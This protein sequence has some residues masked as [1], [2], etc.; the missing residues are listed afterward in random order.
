MI[1]GAPQLPPGYAIFYSASSAGFDFYGTTW[2]VFTTTGNDQMEWDH[3]DD[4]NGQNA[5][6]A[7]AVRQFRRLKSPALYSFC[8][9]DLCA[10]GIT[11]YAGLL[12]ATD[13]DLYGTTQG[14]GANRAGTVFKIG[15]TGAL[16]TLYSFCAVGGAECKDGAAPSATL[17]Q[18]SDGSFYGTTPLG[19]RNGHGTVFKIS[20][21]G[22][23]S[24]LYS[25]CS[26]G[27]GECTDGAAPSAGLTQG[28]DG[29][30]YGVTES[31]GAYA[32]GGTAFRIAPTGALTTLY[33]FCVIA[34]VDNCQEGTGIAHGVGLLQG[35]DGNLYGTT[36]QDGTVFR[37]TTD[38]AL[39]TLYTFCS[40]AKCADGFLPNA[41]LIEGIDGNFYGTTAG[42]GAHRWGT[43]FRLTPGGRLTTLYNFCSSAHCADGR[44]PVGSLTQGNHGDLYGVTQA[45]GGAEDGG[46]V[47]KITAAG[48]FTTLVRFCAQSGC[49]DGWSPSAGLAR[50]A[51]GTLYGTTAAGG[52]HGDGTVFT[53]P[54]DQASGE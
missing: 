29:N 9:E 52:A 18:G 53:L 35:S 34:E 24:T 22:R 4:Y 20:A 23:L 45:G 46:T 26:L 31:G 10:D 41:G 21:N 40:L 39:R 19:G 28:R 50:G 38:G 16:T 14:G 33:S 8:S 54:T 44:Y 12:N 51:N 15:T 49:A 11:P 2:W 27:G 43:I 30:F 36:A 25:F 47:F 37:I 13:G 48:A 1:H 5:G 42:G 7:L 6:A 17:I 32:I 3:N